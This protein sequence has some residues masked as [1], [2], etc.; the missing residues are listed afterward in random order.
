MTDADNKS[1]PDIGEGRLDD[2]ASAKLEFLVRALPDCSAGEIMSVAI[3]R[4]Y[5][6]SMAAG[7]DLMREASAAPKH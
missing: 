4:F 2:D 5:D 7:G 6:D 1:G 3:R